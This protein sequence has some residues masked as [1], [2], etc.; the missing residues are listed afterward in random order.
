MERKYH[1]VV[2]QTSALE[3][4]MLRLGKQR[5]IDDWRRHVHARVVIREE[6]DVPLAIEREEKQEEIRKIDEEI[7]DLI[8]FMQTTDRKCN[9]RVAASAQMQQD[10]QECK[11][12]E[13][14]IH[15]ERNRR[16]SQSQHARAY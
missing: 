4:D 16:E 11:S 12:L 2:G 7:Q 3:E 10:V 5:E 14:R 13:A 9:Q 8:A 15:A 1:D 6:H